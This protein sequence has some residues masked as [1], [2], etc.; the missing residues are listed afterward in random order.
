MKRFNFLTNAL[1]LIL[2]SSVLVSCGDLDFLISKKKQSSVDPAGNGDGSGGGTTPT[3]PEVK[4]SSMVYLTSETMKV[5]FHMDY[6]GAITYLSPANS[7]KNIINNHDLGRQ[8]QYA[9]YSFPI[10][11]YKPNGVSPHP[12]WQGIGWDPIQTGDVYGNGS[13]VIERRQDGNKLYFKTIPM[14]WGYNNVPCECTVETYAELKGNALEIRN[15]LQV[16][17][18]DNFPLLGRGQDLG[19]GFLTSDFTRAKAYLGLAPYTGS[20]ITDIDL[21]APPFTNNNTASVEMYLPEGWT[22][23]YNSKGVG[24][25]LWAPHTHYFSVELMGKANEGDEYSG[26]TG[27][28]GA[29]MP[30][31][32]DRNIRY[33]SKVAY[34]M[35]SVEDVRQYAV[36]HKEEQIKPNFY[37]TS[38]RQ[39]W[40]FYTD[41]DDG[42]FPFNGEWSFKLDKYPVILFS[43][44]IF[45]DSQKD[46]KLYFQVAYDGTGKQMNVSCF[47]QRS[48]RL[49]DYSDASTAFNLINDGQYHTYELPVGDMENW[50]GIIRKIIISVPNESTTGKRLKIKSISIT[51]PN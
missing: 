27:R 4:P 7:S 14:Q 38:D 23:L 49:N 26:N 39:H 45:W 33:E 5:G 3:P 15:V 10:E 6:G 43:P 35:G 36:S 37:F 11:T 16:N 9:Y 40:T 34:I 18:T 41:T 8:L 24:L 21:T 1:T 51:K 13:R 48:S 28:F 30:E 12:A 25:G 44:D 50:Q 19:G 46:K 29:H 42:G 22:Y 32:L 17:R 2:F 20:N 31:V 47:K